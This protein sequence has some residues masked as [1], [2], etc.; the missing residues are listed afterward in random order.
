LGDGIGVILVKKAIIVGASSG[1]GRELA[2]IFSINA[3]VLGLAARRD[4]LL[5][6]LQNELETKSYIKHID[7][8]RQD[9]AMNRLT[10]LIAE[11]KDVDLIIITSGIGHINH[12][13][14]WKKEKETIDVN[15]SGVTSMINVS[16]KHFIEK[17]SGQLVV[18]SSVAA[19]RGGSDGPAYNASKAYIANY[20]EGIRCKFK[21]DKTNIT[22]TDIR[23]GLV[24][25]DMAKGEGLFWVQ[26]PAKVARQIYDA[27][28]LHKKVVYVTKRWGLIAFLVKHIP[29]WIYNKF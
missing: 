1:I 13:L 4:D 2:R 10:E 27:I 15:V 5:H 22:V 23:P 24:D 14:D 12:E 7:I 26:P 6:A 29:D 11:M 21:K 20:L 9:E 19:L 8:S 3:Y 16:L 25:T 18:I 17:N 28:K